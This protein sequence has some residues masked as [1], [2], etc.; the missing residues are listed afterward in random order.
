[1]RG[2]ELVGRGTPAVITKGP[3]LDAYELVVNAR[4]LETAG[5]YG[6]YPALSASAPGPL[7]ALERAGQGWALVRRDAN[8]PTSFSLPDAF[9]PATHQHF[10]FRQQTD[11][12]LTVHLEAHLLADLSLP[13]VPTRVG[14]AV[15]HGTAAFEMVRVTA[16]AGAYSSATSNT[17]P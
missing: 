14:L 7:L 8:L 9:D 10:R 12:R 6:F 1:M 11:G 2:G 5:G 4:L 13:P 17:I 3:L 15:T 16:L